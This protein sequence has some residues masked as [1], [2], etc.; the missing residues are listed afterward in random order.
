MEKMERN[1]VN[2]QLRID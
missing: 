1:Q 2:I